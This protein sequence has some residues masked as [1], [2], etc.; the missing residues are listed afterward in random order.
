MF[1]KT[2]ITVLLVVV[3]CTSL[4]LASDA[5]YYITVGRQLMF[6]GTLPGLRLA[7]ETFD[8]GLKDQTCPD[9][10]TSR[11]LKFWRAVTGMTML[12]IRDD[13]GSIDSVLELARQF[14]IEVL[15]DC[16]APYLEPLGLDFEP[17]LNQY[18][19]YEIPAGA[20]DAN[21]V[22]NIIDTSMIPEIEA[23]IDD[24]NSIS[25][26]TNDR[27]QVF[28]EPDE[29]RIFFHPNSP[30]FNPGSPEHDP[31]SRFL[32]PLE[33]DYGEVLLLK[34]LLITLKAQLRAQA[35]YDLYTDANDMLVEKFYGDTLNINADVLDPHPDLLKVLPTSNDASDGAAILAKARQDLIEGIDYYLEAVTYISSEGDPQDDEFL[36][37][38]PNDK[39]VSDAINE[40]L[41][42]LRDSLVN[43]T[44]EIYTMET[45]KR[46]D[47]QCS[48]SY[49]IGQLELAFDLVGLEIGGELTLEQCAGVPSC[50]DFEDFSIEGDE[51]Y[52]EM[53]FEGSSI[54]YMYAHS[55]NWANT[56]LLTPIECGPN[57]S[58]Y[59]CAL[60]DEN[61]F[62]ATGTAQGW[63]GYNQTWSY[64]LPFAFPFFGTTYTSV[65]VCTNGFLDFTD[66]DY[67]YWNWQNK[68]RIQPFG[69]Y[70]R[71]D[72]VGSYDIYIDQAGPNEV[73]IRWDADY[74]GSQCNFSVS[75]FSDGSVRFDYGPGNEYVNP[76]VGISNGSYDSSIPLGGWWGSGLFTGNIS[77]DQNSITDATFEYWGDISG[78]L[79]GLS[80]KIT[81][82]EVQDVNVDFNP[83][84]GSSAR[85][86][87]PVNP[88]D[89]LPVFDEWNAA[90]PNTVG[91][92]LDDD[93]TLGGITPDMSQYDWQ[94]LFDLQ[95]SGLFYLDLISPSQ[96]Q[97]DGEVD[98]WTAEQLVFADIKG[99]TE[100]DSNDVKGVDIKDVYMAYDFDNVYGA[101][102]LNDP[103]TDPNQSRSYSLTLSYSPD[104][105]STL[106][107]LRFE[108]YA[109]RDYIDGYLRHMTYD[110]WGWAWWQDVAVLD[111]AVGQSA[112]EFK[113]PFA[114]IPSDLYGRFIS[115]KSWGWDPG[116]HR[117]DREE[118]I[119]HLRIG[120]VGTVSGTI[121]YSGYRGAPIFI[122]A[123]TDPDDPEESTVADTM[124]LEPGPYT[125]DGIGLGWQG[126][127]R[128][129]TPL[130]GFN[131]FDLEALAIEATVSVFMF[132]TD[133]DGV[134]IV[135][136]NP[137]ILKKDIWVFGEIDTILNKK[138]LYAF[139]AVKGGTYTLDVNRLTSQYASMTLFGRDGHTDIEELYYWQAQ[140][141][142]WLCPVSGRYYV[143]V[144]D[145]NWEP[146][147][148]TYQI[149]MTSDLTCPDADIASADWVG[150]KDC[151][152]DFYD[153]TVLVS[154]WLDRCSEPYWCDESDF[155]QSRSIDF[156]DFALMANEWL[157][158]GIP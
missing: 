124:I 26:E 125:L 17:A 113:V 100:G 130:F 35:A 104:N 147:G 56:V 7:Y 69:S 57:P 12:V 31:N 51:L 120:S 48:D 84:F 59:K 121:T 62:S 2:L 135:L 50:W 95:P 111:Y 40:K 37:I 107:S 132:N 67:N 14:D 4:G 140:Q 45:T 10:N 99:D 32:Q 126:Y 19:A 75:L 29:I 22:R 16:W 154:Q 156:V 131:V 53:D 151:K 49:S 34:A 76:Y 152:V 136:N 112:V 36:Y 73:K 89:L 9:C 90:Q 65:Y 116:W 21:E 102:S 137:P 119:T 127:V 138:D 18:D 58:T 8:N 143:K 105:P 103:V 117:H 82:I 20:P 47:I 122:Q 23:I 63:H 146:E 92:G 114:D 41:T 110:E 13:S 109:S 157:H 60:L 83:V 24:L 64:M 133:I 68:V 85:Y 134:D 158:D 80:G 96:I 118:N 129:F 98:D 30:V 148:G 5:D 39:K 54:N 94:V 25:D 6:D 106:D 77:Q 72:Q 46:Y 145:T 33:V 93:A 27:F 86:P 88:R 101:I 38:D 81:D 11:E 123:Y 108:V 44:P 144:Q 70:L 139:D 97:I 149:R 55:L 1:R 155:N 74:Y 52:I 79:S 87:D 42:M 150:V 141:I 142:N 71:T 66:S 15:G 28:L 61:L 115:V 78:T 91:H 153:L 128:A 3:C 43:D